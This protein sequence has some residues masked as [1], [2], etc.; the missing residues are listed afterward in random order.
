MNLP[1]HKISSEMLLCVEDIK[2]RLNLV[3]YKK[4]P[5]C[6]NQ[7]QKNLKRLVKERKSN[8]QAK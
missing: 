8:E 7:L 3:D 6:N 2:D 5:T 4:Q 1:N